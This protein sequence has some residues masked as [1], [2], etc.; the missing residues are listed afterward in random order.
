MN[1]N[2]QCPIYKAARL[3]K[4]LFGKIMVAK[5]P[6]RAS[7]V[8]KRNSRA[9]TKSRGGRGFPP[10]SMRVRPGYF[11]R[12][13]KENGTKRTPSCTIP[14]LLIAYTQKLEILVTAL[15]RASPSPK[16]QSAKLA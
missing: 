15:N 5:P 16:F 10:A 6:V 11:C 8:G 1:L 12:E 7:K 13:L 4:A 3:N 9:L 2:P 14:L